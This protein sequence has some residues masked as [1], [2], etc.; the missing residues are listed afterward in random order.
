MSRDLQEFW[1]F[2]MAKVKVK[3]IFL[4]FFELIIPQE[5]ACQKI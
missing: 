2:Y 4:N 5:N 3:V 1:Y